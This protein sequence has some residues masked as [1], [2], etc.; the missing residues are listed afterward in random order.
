M[1]S[2]MESPKN[3]ILQ[4]VMILLMVHWRY[5]LHAVVRC[6]HVVLVQRGATRLVFFAHNHFVHGLA[7]NVK[8][9]RNYPLVAVHL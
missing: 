8:E 7:N 9:G 1:K 3:A 4:R 2:L 6:E 5:Q